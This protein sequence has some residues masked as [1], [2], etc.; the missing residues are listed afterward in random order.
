[1]MDSDFI[2]LKN[3]F[4]GFSGDNFNMST[5]K[6]CVLQELSKSIDDI[7]NYN[8]LVGRIKRSKVLDHIRKNLF[9]SFEN[10]SKGLRQKGVCRDIGAGKY[11]TAD[12]IQLDI[13]ALIKL[14]AD[15]GNAI[16]CKAGLIGISNYKES[17][18]LREALFLMMQDCL[19]YCSIERFELI[20]SDEQDTPNRFAVDVTFELDG[21]IWL[22]QTWN[23]AIDDSCQTTVNNQYLEIYKPVISNVLVNAVH[24]IS[25]LIALDVIKV[26]L[27]KDKVRT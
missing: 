2:A 11:L 4:D 20:D 24:G 18:A 8:A 5:I 27:A 16:E 23:G 12:G 13:S 9:L 6:L 19:E 7:E 17:D 26:H 1:M 14:E 10:K 3:M 22:V 25:S 15:L 21:M